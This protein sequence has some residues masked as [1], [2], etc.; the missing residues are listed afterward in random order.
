MSMSVAVR[1]SPAVF[2]LDQHVGQDRNGVAALHDA[3]HMS[4]G[5][6]AKRG[7]FDGEFH[8]PGH[9]I[10]SRLPTRGAALVGLFLCVWASFASGAATGSTG[11]RKAGASRPLRSLLFALLERPEEARRNSPNQEHVSASQGLLSGLAGSN[12]QISPEPGPEGPPGSPKRPFRPVGLRPPQI[13][14]VRHLPARGPE[15]ARRGS[16]CP[17]SAS[18]VIRAPGVERPKVGGQE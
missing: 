17:G 14:G 15:A 5:A 10:N 11:A 1:V 13:P 8:G 9:P 2:R 7:A 6:A 12:S 3:L 18:R 4:Q 16:D